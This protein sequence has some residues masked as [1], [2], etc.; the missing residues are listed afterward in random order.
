VS[1]GVFPMRIKFILAVFAIIWLSLLIRVYNISIQSNDYYDALANRNTIKTKYIAPIR[2]EILDRNKKPLAINKL[3]FRIKFTPHLSRKSKVKILEEEIDL[4]V[5]YI[6]A[7]KKEELLK[8]YK[9]KDSYYNHKPIE[10]VNFI[11]YEDILPVYS[12]L[13]LRE[14]LI[15]E[16]APKRYYPYKELSAHI[17]GYVAK[18]D[19]KA[20]DKDHVVKMTGFIGKNGVEKFYN[21]YLQGESGYRQI[22]VSAYNEEIEELKN[23][24]PIEN[25]NLV[26]S[27]DIELQK[28]IK[29]LFGKETGVAIVMDTK[30]SILASVSLPEYDLNTFVSGI[31]YKKWQELISDVNAPFTNKIINGLYPPGS[32]IKTGL[33]LIYITSGLMGPWNTFDCTGSMS[34][35]KRNF[36]CWKNKGHG[37]TNI[38]KAIRESC[39][40]YFY[41]GSLKVG[42]A[43]MSKNLKR[44]GLGKKTGVDLPNEFIGTMPNKEWKLKKYNQR[45]VT[46][47]TLNSSIGQGDTLVTPMQIAQY[48]AL[49]A[50]GKLPIPH[51]AWQVG[52]ET[53]NPSPVEVL[54]DDEKARLPL[55]R[56]AMREVCSS[57]KGTAVN[58]VRKKIA[59]AGKTGTAQVIG[60]AQETKKRLK[61]HELAYFKRSHAWFTTFAPYERPEY[62]VTILVE[63]GGHGGAAAGPMTSKIYEWLYEHKYLKHRR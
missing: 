49:M 50:T 14:H 37:E 35:G 2:G 54:T 62:I 25:R 18:A 38:I 20:V 1:G 53:Y 48:T 39:D 17:L 41:K 30:G 23:V 33:G 15:L 47:E 19:K 31:S 59:M 21:N 51:L 4:L 5:K 43:N 13:N 44:Y 45:W 12:R 3:G 57:P 52:D 60:I 11:G 40:D 56:R 9:E 32:V 22:K 58:F 36:R 63:H 55:I 10:V 29:E 34:L 26:L 6:P 8:T 42:I 28:Y 16:P 46:G 27:I 7:L 24:K 61:E